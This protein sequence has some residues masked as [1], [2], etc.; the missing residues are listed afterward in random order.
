M[1]RFVLSPAAAQDLED[2]WEYVAF[3]SIEAADRLITKLHHQVRALAAMPGMGHRRPDL[4]DDRPILFWPVGSYLII[5][6]TSD[7]TLEIV[8][9][10]HGKRDIPSFIRRRGL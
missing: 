5:Y 1:K 7:D 10:T 9:F 6:R 8:A 2:I 3:D 4:A